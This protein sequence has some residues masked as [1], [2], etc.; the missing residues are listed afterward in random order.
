MLGDD[1]F[2]DKQGIEKTIHINLTSAIIL[3]RM[4]L[5]SMLNV[6]SGHIINMSSSVDYTCDL[7]ATSN[8]GAEMVH[9]VDRRLLT[10]NP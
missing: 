2:A 8:D 9:Y 6:G 4:V 10:R 1:R 5:P 7:D 3:A